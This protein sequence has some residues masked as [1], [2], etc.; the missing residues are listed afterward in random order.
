MIEVGVG[1]LPMSRACYITSVGPAVATG[2]VSKMSVLSVVNTS[3][4]TV[5]SAAVTA[6][7]A[8]IIGARTGRDRAN[9][10]HALRFDVFLRADRAR[11]Y[12]AVWSVVAPLKYP[13]INALELRQLASLRR[14]LDEFYAGDGGLYLSRRAVGN[15]I[16]LWNYID[17]LL[18]AGTPLQDETRRGVADR[19]H[20]VRRCL[21]Q[22]LGGRSKSP[23]AQD[24]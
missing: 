3:I 18:E 21:T 6:G 11:T 4:I 9:R 17:E 19:A 13:E 24:D 8:G 15:L 12:P 14:E 7:V 23:A 16:S 20:L 5:G 1:A 22:D 10:Q 2:G